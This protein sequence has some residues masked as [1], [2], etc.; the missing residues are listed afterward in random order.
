M[1]EKYTFTAKEIAKAAASALENWD[2][3][4][5]EE[6]PSRHRKAYDACETKDEFL[7]EISGKYIAAYKAALE[8]TEKDAEGLWCEDGSMTLDQAFSDIWD[9]LDEFAKNTA[10]NSI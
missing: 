10:D 5:M 1:T 2:F 4:V 6:V 8:I 9:F 7:K 3:D